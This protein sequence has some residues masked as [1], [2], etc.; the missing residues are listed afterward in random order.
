MRSIGH[1]SAATV[2]VFLAAGLGAGAS[3]FPEEKR[4]HIRRFLPVQ[5]LD[6]ALRPA[7]VTALVENYRDETA[8]VTLELV[9]PEGVRAV[10][11]D[12]TQSAAIEAMDGQ[13]FEWEILADSAGRSELR[14]DAVLADGTAASST[15]SMLFLEPREVEAL[16]YIPDPVPVEKTLLVGA[17]HC[18]LWEV[19]RPE[20]WSQL[21]KHPERTPALGFYAQENPEVA[22]WETKWAVDHGVD[23]F[24]Y[25]WYRASQGKP[26]EMRFGS[27]IH[28]ALFHSRFVDTMKFT[29]M[30]ENQV[31]G[32]SG[33][34]DERD[35]MENLFPFWMEN[36]FKHPSYLVIDNKP[37]LF[38]YRPEYLIQ[39]LGSEENVAK[40]LDRI[41]E[42]SR[43]AGFDGLYL[44]GEYRGL[45]AEHLQQMKRLGLDYT[46]AY[47]W[48]VPNSP[49]PAQAV[50]AQLN[51]I[52]KTQEMGI[53]PQVVTV[54]QGWS[55]WADEGS[56]WKI[57]PPEYAG[58]LREAKSFVES[59]P[60]DELGS[61]MLLLDNWNEWG[62]GHYIAPH[63]EFGFGY[64]D[65]VRDALTDAPE[66]HEDLLPED[67]GLGPYDTAYH[68]YLRRDT[69]LRRHVRER[70]FK[71]G[72]PEDGLI[73]WWS[74]DEDI[75]APTTLDYSGHRLGGIL[76]DAARA[77]GID[78]NALVCSGG[79]VEVFS[80]PKL[81][82]ENISVT[83]WVKT[84]RA[85]LDNRWFLNRVFS[86]GTSAGYRMGLLSGK[87]SFQIPVTSWTH[88]LTGETPLP[89]GRWV[90]LAGTFDGEEMRLYMDGELQGVM[91]RRGPV[92]P[93]TFRLVLGTYAFKHWAH[94]EGL[95]D[96]VRLYDRALTAEE[97]RAQYQALAARAEG[98]KTYRN[99][100]I[101]II[102][103]ADPC[104]IR[105]RGVYYLYPTWD[106]KGYDVFVSDDLVHWQKKGKCFTDPRGGVWAPDVFHNTR[107]DGK[108]YL[109]YTANR[110]GGGKLIG[111]AV[112]DDP[113]G[114][115]E[116]QGDLV[117]SA[118]DA[119]LFQDD[120]GAC[121]M[122]YTCLAQGFRIMVQPMADPLTKQGDPLF[123][124]GPS[125][126]WEQAKGHVTEGPW[127]LKR[128]GVYYLMYSGSG[129]DGPD[130][131]IG[132]ATSDSPT[133][134]F[135]KHPG[136]PI[137]K[138]GDGV[139]GPGHHC[140]VTGPDGNLWM[141]YHQQNS[142]E[143]SWNRFLALD[144][145]W[146]DD[147]GV[148]HARTTRGIDQPAPQP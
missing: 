75:E 42:A 43:A 78:G 144:P 100:I 25:C 4:I 143:V 83:C 16:E 131:A 21:I 138:R 18:P 68:A 33:V 53:L 17:H 108:F 63:R 41:R 8:H 133:G 61:R 105:H 27:A 135:V 87:P 46:F 35:L 128:D 130:Y 30:W 94:F 121:Y 36:Y 122:Y 126:S 110:P 9:L 140:V 129:T 7:R 96:E 111:V 95:L 73:A 109:Y 145:L 1:W 13:E 76:R 6:R 104:V 117:E 47:C 67:I 44:L 146:F 79:G 54:S 141:V 12:T 23:F 93:S 50:E 147:Q 119:H 51:Y 70:V 3:E 148:I 37:V 58:L 102:G 66:P 98:A 106:S 71:D 14:L 57:P 85:D 113:L 125:E 103:P 92:N 81:S 97:V 20:M 65:A 142:E 5:P 82:P 74:F 112:A 137:A 49:E 32:V 123:L 72:A 45:S 99:P 132:Y 2:A 38:I 89:T 120:D 55:G 114:P 31:R 91:E 29:I 77:L 28:Q 22:D 86:G 11:G 107:G 88:H 48:Y 40:A 52:R 134:P 64:L 60:P 124:F 84:D 139:Y 62:E 80:D 90:H 69:E 115:F 24:I 34:A 56:I 59:L 26:V 19:D 116:N 15:L 118:I 10:A 39:D 136:N 101:D 127:M